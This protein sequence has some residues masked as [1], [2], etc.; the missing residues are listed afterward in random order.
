MTTFAPRLQDVMDEDPVFL[1]ALLDS[2]LEQQ[3]AAGVQ[4]SRG[5]NNH[6]TTNSS[7]KIGQTPPA[8][9]E[10]IRHLP[11]LELRE[12]DLADP[13]NRECCVCLDDNHVGD[14][15]VRLPHCCHIFHKE[16]ILDWLGRK[17]TC[18]VCR[19]EH[20]TEDA[21]FEVERLERL[22]QSKPRYA[23]HELRRMTH[24]ELVALLPP[25][26]RSNDKNYH[27][28]DLVKYLIE[29]SAVDVV[30]LPDP[31]TEYT[32][33]SLQTMPVPQLRNVMNKEA[34]VFWLSKDVTTREQLLQIFLDSGRLLVLPEPPEGPRPPVMSSTTTTTTTTPAT[35][36]QTDLVATTAITT[37]PKAGGGSGGGSILPHLRDENN[38]WNQKRGLLRKKLRLFFGPRK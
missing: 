38:T 19:Y 13:V 2:Y 30:N 35:T 5:D 16:C 8:S 18:P 6:T 14:K 24:A 25:D 32:M 22:E 28:A 37:Q 26:D 9:A 34:G 10:M 12:E 27:G 23:R 7:S 11:L 21:D 20:P 15:A 17:C 33:S 29:S 36:K 4:R 1:Q 31:V 3:Q